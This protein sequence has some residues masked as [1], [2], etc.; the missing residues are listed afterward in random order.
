MN[1]KIV[2]RD[3]NRVIEA[4]RKFPF[5]IGKTFPI[6]AREEIKP[7][8]RDVR[9]RIISKKWPRN[10][11]IGSSI[12]MDLTKT[13]TKKFK[14]PGEI[15]ISFKPKFAGPASLFEHGS[16]GKRFRKSGASTGVLFG[17]PAF[18]R[19]WEWFKSIGNRNIQ[20]AFIRASM[21]VMN[22]ELRRRGIKI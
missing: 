21:R 11:K 6:T 4:H 8:K 5:L 2:S 9:N 22:L 7:W 10:F 17:K 1:I 14:A 20:P 15:G 18:A 12:G 16:K 19:S 3:L 13:T